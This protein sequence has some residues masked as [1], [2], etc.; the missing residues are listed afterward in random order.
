MWRRRINSAPACN[1]RPTNNASRTCCA[2]PISPALME[3]LTRKMPARLT[4]KAPSH[5]IQF[6]FRAVRTGFS[7]TVTD[8]CVTG[9]SVNAGAGSAVLFHSE[10]DQVGA[11]SGSYWSCK[12]SGTDSRSRSRSKSGG[13][14]DA[15]GPSRST[16]RRRANS[17]FRA[18]TS[19]SSSC[20]SRV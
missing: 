16:A 9:R 10:A 1:A 18:P 11:D 15:G 17:P 8:A 14:S 5:T 6:S 19:R 12:G 4:L 2:G 7:D 13:D 3:W 20:N